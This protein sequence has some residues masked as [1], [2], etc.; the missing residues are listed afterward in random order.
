MRPALVA[1]SHGTASSDGQVA[2][3]ELVGAVRR[4]LVDVDV[5]DAFVDVQE[6]ALASVLEGSPGPSVVIPLLLTPGFHVRVDVARAIATRQATAAPVLGPDAAIT[7]IL[8]DRLDAVGLRDD[9]AVVLGVAGSSDVRA[10]H[11]TD[12]AAT[13]LAMALGREVRVGHLG[14]IG[15]PIGSVAAEAAAAGRRVVAATYLL[16][17]GHFTDLMNRCGADAV[18]RPVLGGGSPD[19]RL[20]QLVVDRYSEAAAKWQLRRAS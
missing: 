12:R 3:A 18:T 19:D 4:R 8:L 16:A 2:V 20:V 14:G 11:S 5:L 6:P 15:R 7:A 13:R 17:P 9:D 1:V 10:R